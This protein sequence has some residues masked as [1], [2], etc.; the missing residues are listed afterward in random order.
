MPSCSVFHH[1]LGTKLT[2]YCIVGCIKFLTQL[3]SAFLLPLYCTVRSLQWAWIVYMWALPG[4]QSYELWFGADFNIEI[5]SSHKASCT[6]AHFLHIMQLH[7]QESDGWKRWA[8]CTRSI[9]H[10]LWMDSAGVA[11][12][13]V[14]VIVSAV[15]CCSPLTIHQSL[16]SLILMD[17]LTFKTVLPMLWILLLD[18]CLWT[19]LLPNPVDNYSE[20]QASVPEASNKLGEWLSEWVCNFSP[21]ASSATA[22]AKETKFGTKVA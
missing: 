10:C 9:S 18:F 5:S 1:R 19:S 17:S 3:T 14:D 8:K 20:A 7:W 13:L 11:A 15:F 22:A 2:T 12:C 4:W 6:I 16:D 21:W